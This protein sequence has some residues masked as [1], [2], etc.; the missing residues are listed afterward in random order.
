[1]P[2]VFEA[3]PNHVAFRVIE[4]HCR[5]PVI[6]F[7][8][9]LRQLDAHAVLSRLAD[10]LAVRRVEG[11]RQQLVRDRDLHGTLHGQAL[12]AAT[13]TLRADDQFLGAPCRVSSIAVAGW[14]EWLAVV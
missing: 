1:M 3:L 4:M 11:E 6:A 8:A 9:V 2:G 7:G 13:H 10:W 14:F 5:E 12:A